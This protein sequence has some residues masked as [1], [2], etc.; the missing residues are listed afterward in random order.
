MSDST[1]LTI[2]TALYRA[3][4]SNREIEVLVNQVGWLSGTVVGLDGHGVVFEEAG[5]RTWCCGSR[6]SSPSASRAAPPRCRRTRSPGSRSRRAELTAPVP[7]RA[8]HRCLSAS[9]RERPD[10]ASSCPGQAAHPARVGPGVLAQRPPDG[11]AQEEL[12]L[13]HRR[14]DGIHEQLQVG[15]LAVPELADE[16]GP[17]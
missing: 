5:R 3:W 12:A 2:G 8:G 1:V 13:G 6:Q 11:L 17:A 15:A 9:R 14:F 16:G 10:R 4:N 7:R